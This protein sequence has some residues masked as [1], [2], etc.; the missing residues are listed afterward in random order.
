MRPLAFLY[1]ALRSAGWWLRSAAYAV[2]ALA[3]PTYRVR[4][5]AGWA[6]DMARMAWMRAMLE[7]RGAHAD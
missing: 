5:A 4:S 3:C 2:L 7:I 1:H 6:E